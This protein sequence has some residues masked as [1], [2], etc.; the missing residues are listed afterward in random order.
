MA[1]LFQ[2]GEVQEPEIHRFLHLVDIGWHEEHEGGM[3]LHLTHLFG[4]VRIRPGIEQEREQ[5]FLRLDPGADALGFAFGWPSD[6]PGRV[7]HRVKGCPP[8]LAIGLP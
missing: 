2:G 7:D 4:P 3:G 5:L 1:A 6:H 8:F